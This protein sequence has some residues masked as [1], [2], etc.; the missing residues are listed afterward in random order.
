MAG[1]GARHGGQLRRRDGH[2]EQAH[3]QRIEKLR[4]GERGHGAGGQQA[5]QQRIHVRADL[6]HAA[7][8][9]DRHEAAQH[10]ADARRA[11]AERR[12]QAPDQTEYPG[13]LHGELQ[14]TAQ[15]RSPGQGHR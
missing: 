6:H 5:G 8:D 4:V 11:Q 3:G 1:H 15:H 10:R 7:A 14:R 9:E 2:P 13:K 12:S